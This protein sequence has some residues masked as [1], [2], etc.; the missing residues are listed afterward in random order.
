MDGG[1]SI[2]SGGWRGGGLGGWGDW[3]Y[4][5]VSQ[6]EPQERQRERVSLSVFTAE[7]PS[8][9]DGRMQICAD[10]HQTDVTSR[11]VA[12][13]RE[14]GKAVGKKWGEEDRGAH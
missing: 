4:E 1:K 10:Y 6:T 13:E 3:W 7:Q 5:A 14:D 12:M 11:C 8:L 9:S 2:P